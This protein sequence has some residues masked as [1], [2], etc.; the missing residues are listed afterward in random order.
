MNTIK[1]ERQQKKEKS[2]FL[3]KVACK[4]KSGSKLL[5]MT[6]SGRGTHIIRE[7]M[8]V[9]PLLGIDQRPPRSHIGHHPETGYPDGKESSH[10]RKEMGG[11]HFQ[12]RV[13]VMKKGGTEESGDLH[14]TRMKGD[15]DHLFQEMKLCP[16]GLGE[17]EGFLCCQMN[18][19]EGPLG[20]ISKMQD[21]QSQRM[22]GTESLPFQGLNQ[23]LVKRKTKRKKNHQTRSQHK[24]KRETGHHF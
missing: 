14:L 9:Q 8:A 12:E 23:N 19:T 21:L 10:L 20:W 1:K 5:T 24:R 17:T 22:T 16:L 18:K 6:L 7:N 3:I 13:S 15:Q 2:L 4:L 11:H